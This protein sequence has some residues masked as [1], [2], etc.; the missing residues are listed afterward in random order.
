MV[1]LLLDLGLGGCETGSG[2]LSCV[3]TFGS[4]LAPKLSASQPH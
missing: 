1:M 4:P 3:R 2:F